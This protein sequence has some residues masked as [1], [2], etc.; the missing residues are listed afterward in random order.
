MENAQTWAV[1]GDSVD[2]LKILK[3]L[4]NDLIIPCCSIGSNLNIH[5]V[6]IHHD[7]PPGSNH[8]K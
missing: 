3:D 8:E 7:H 6:K 2:D 5:Q 4:P 1:D